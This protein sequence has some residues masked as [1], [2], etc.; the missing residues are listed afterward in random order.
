MFFSLTLTWPNMAFPSL[1][2]EMV[3][4]SGIFRWL[5]SMNK[6]NMMWIQ[7]KKSVSK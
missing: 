7:I 6:S 2:H 3:H 1:S 4:E 5:V